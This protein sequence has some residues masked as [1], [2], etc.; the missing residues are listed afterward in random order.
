[1]QTGTR[2]KWLSFA[3]CILAG[4]LAV[5]TKQIAATLPIFIVLYEWYFFRGLSL[6]WGRHHFLI[7]G[8]IMSLLLIIALIYLDYNPI[9]RILSAYQHRDFTLLQRMLTQFRV[10]VFYVSLLLWPQPSRLNLDHD[11]ALSYS[12]T[13][14]VTTLISVVVVT[15][16]IALAIL[17]A[18]QEPLL[19]YGILW[20]FGNLAIESS[21]IGLELV[22]EHRNYLP[23]MFI[24]LAMVALVFQYVKATWMGIVFLC[25]VGI[26]FTVWTFERNQVWMD[27]MSLYRDCAEKSPAKARPHN[28]FGAILLR[29][30]RLPAAIDEFQA[31]LRIKPDYADAHYNLGNALVKQGNLN[32]G[33][34]HFSEV[35]GLQPG[36]VKALNNMA[37]TLVLLERYPE[38]IENFKKAL[39]I[40]PTDP[41]LHRNLA[42]VMKKQ[43][44]LEGA[45]RHFSRA[46]E[47]NPENVT[48]RRNLEEIESR[49][50][51][52]FGNRR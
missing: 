4:V 44:D 46:L 26:L 6:K 29:R 9:I 17:T 15:A 19:S 22:F 24:I 10:V 39:T 36:N 18:K 3:G 11:F 51:E 25:V 40:N 48:A 7:L 33:I 42:V 8:G 14:P 30:G 37:A 12:L 35:L 1:L 45:K 31:A 21:V 20:F 13:D 2:S 16:L 34:Y 41:D 28:N 23:S 52:A 50:R 32:N 27:E 49:M 47:I 5:G 43:G 38:A